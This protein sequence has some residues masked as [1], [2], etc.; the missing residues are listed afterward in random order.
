SPP[1]GKITL[2]ARGQEIPAA[3]IAPAGAAGA[4]APAPA[5]VVSYGRGAIARASHLPEWMGSDWRDLWIPLALIALSTLA[6][7]VVCAVVWYGT[8]GSPADR[9]FNLSI[10]I[11]WDISV[12]IIAGVFIA[13]LFDTSLGVV[14]IALLKLVAVAMARFAVWAVI[15]VP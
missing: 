3:I 7:V 10:R 13:W 9:L 15:A 8:G 4:G 1:P 5:R 11:A 14:W 12:T 2:D 6:I